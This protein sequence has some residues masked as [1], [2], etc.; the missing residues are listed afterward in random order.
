MENLSENRQI[1]WGPQSSHWPP[2]PLVK[3]IPELGILSEQFLQQHKKC[4]EGEPTIKRPAI[5]N[6]GNGMQQGRRLKSLEEV[7]A[8][9][10]HIVSRTY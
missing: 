6:V 7:W 2:S 5:G 9:K 10:A 8:A 4:N 3:Q 1:R